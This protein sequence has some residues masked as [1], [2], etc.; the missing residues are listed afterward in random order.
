MAM[1]LA[2]G[3]TTCRQDAAVSAMSAAVVPL[4][5]AIGMAIEAPFASEDLD[6]DTWTS[7]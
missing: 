3:S 4:R 6:P 5:V 1:L 2:V 7:M